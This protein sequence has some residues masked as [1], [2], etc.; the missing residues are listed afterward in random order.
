MRI[1]KALVLVSL[2][3]FSLTAS[4]CVDEMSGTT[5]SVVSK[6]NVRQ[7]NAVNTPELAKKLQQ[8]KTIN[9]F[10]PWN[11]YKSIQKYGLHWT[12]SPTLSLNTISL[13][14]VYW[15]YHYV[16]KSWSYYT[17]IE[18]YLTNR[19]WNH[20]AEYGKTLATQTTNPDFQNFI[21]GVIQEKTMR[22]SVDGVMLDWWHDNHKS[23][24]YSESQ[25]RAARI[26][27]AKKIRAKTGNNKIILGNVNWRKDAATA[28]LI[29]GVFLELYKKPYDSASSRLYTSSELAE[30]EKLVEFYELNLAEPKLIALE[31]WRKT[32]KSFKQAGSSYKDDRNSPENRKMA[33]LLTAMSVVIPTNGYI[34]YGDNNPDTPDGDH[35]HEFYDFYLFDIGKPTGSRIKVTDG[36]GY[37]IHQRGFIAYN[38]TSSAKEIAIEGSS[39]T[40]SVQPKTGLFCKSTGS[41][42]DCLSAD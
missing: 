36:I 18:K 26:A 34:L 41:G 7:Q 38:I 6:E 20:D 16:G 32:A 1:T 40:V 42:F 28:N 25:V 12:A 31:G 24:G 33:K 14:E 13:T 2:L 21:T 4:G 10:S 27:I 15:N 11:N 19:N 8:R 29:N 17:G 39:K 23:S 22:K 5:P 37:K 30:I 9:I 3:S 35:D